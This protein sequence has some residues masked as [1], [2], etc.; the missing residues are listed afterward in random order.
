MKKDIFVSMRMNKL[1]TD[2]LEAISA[3]YGT[4]KTAAIEMC[5]TLTHIRLTE[6]GVLKPVYDKEIENDMAVKGIKKITETVMG[7]STK[8]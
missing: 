7:K 1:M 3:V 4:D 6:I 2:K 5:I 8:N